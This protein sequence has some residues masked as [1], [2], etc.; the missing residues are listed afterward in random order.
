M[1]E[2][3]SPDVCADLLR[4]DTMTAIQVRLALGVDGIE[5]TLD[6]ANQAAADPA[7]TLTD[8]GIPLTAAERALAHDALGVPETF[9]GLS[10]LVAAY[11]TDLASLWLE[12]GSPVLSV[13]RP[14]PA[15]LLLARCLERDRIVGTVRYVTAGIP[16]ATLDALTDRI[17]ADLPALAR[18]GIEVT[19]VSSDP[20]TE[21][22]EIGVRAL[23][24]AIRA[25][26]VARYGTVVRVI[27]SPG[28]HPL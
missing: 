11:P 5:G 15:V 19:I 12:G 22:V 23:T 8:Y 24:P 9:T 21:T 28:A 27:E 3:P 4:A 1:P 17:S 14:D 7:S 20:T 13:L 26:L 6:A 25:T 18:D 16:P 10:G 2:R